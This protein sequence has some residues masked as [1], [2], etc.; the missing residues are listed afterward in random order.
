[1][2]IRR[3]EEGF[4]L[5]SAIVLLTV[6]LGLG[7]GLLFLV[8][9]QQ[10][11][12]LGEQGRE[13]AFNVAEAALNSQIGQLSR[14]W[15][16]SKTTEYPPS[17]TALSTTSTNGCPTA[18]SMKVG[19]PNISPGHCTAT[20]EPWGSPASNE[21]TTYV[22]DNAGKSPLFNSTTESTQLA[23]DA[24]GDGKLWVRATGVVQCHVVSIVTVVSRQLVSISIPHDTAVGNWFKVTNTGNKVIV[25]PA[26]VPPVTQA[27]PISMR[28]AGLSPSE[29]EQWSPA[30]EQ[31][32]PN[33]TGAPP[34][35][36]P[37]VNET[38][39]AALKSTAESA[40]TFHSAATGNCPTSLA[41]LGGSP[42]YVEG[43][44]N[45]KL[46]GGVGN[47]ST[48]PGFL[49]LADGTI[50]L[51][52]NAEFYGVIYARNPEDYSGAVVTLGGTAQ[53]FGAID[54]DGK[55]G[56][57]FGSSKANL[58]YNPTAIDALKAYAGA[59]PTRN[60][61]RILPSNQ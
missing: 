59:T 9:G 16:S 28:C 49:V 36:S 46:T 25:N 45:L 23:Y 14:A 20:S 30:K 56:I 48:S 4:A 51:K 17:C 26:G 24:N 18:E 10:K 15:P 60:T 5:V 55:G 33:T 38:E 13:S 6:M 2:S 19:Y 1:M 52:G 50:E 44:G 61:F 27:G 21:W 22:R 7:L 12:A 58:I 32:S 41:T 53:V 34:T 31:I 11:A 47:S 43:C 54:V 3:D 29:C 35:P 37:L 39:L 42:A 8:D 57:E 40:G